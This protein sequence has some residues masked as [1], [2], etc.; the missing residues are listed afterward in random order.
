MPSP[1]PKDSF[2]NITTI[3]IG[4]RGASGVWEIFIPGL[5][6]GELYKYEI[7]TRYQGYIAIKSD[8]FGLL[9]E[10]RPHT[11]SIVWNL[12]CRVLCDVQR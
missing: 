8:P 7:K 3:L 9:S 5:A 4:S 10:M 1:V 6:L 2:T 11:A 12:D